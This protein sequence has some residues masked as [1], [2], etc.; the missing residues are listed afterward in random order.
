ML[1]RCGRPGSAYRPAVRLVSALCAV[2]IMFLY[3]LYKMR[4]PDSGLLTPQQD[5]PELEVEGVNELFLH[6][7]GLPPRL[8]EASRYDPKLLGRHL[9]SSN[10]PY[11]D[12]EAFGDD[13][14]NGSNGTACF[15]PRDKHPGYNTSCLY[16]LDQCGGKAQLFDYLRLVTC[17]FSHVQVRSR[18]KQ[19]PHVSHVQVGYGWE[20][21]Q[22]GYG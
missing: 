17:D 13:D 10:D 6:Q 16:V 11:K 22:V 19:L 18:G 7:E 12:L 1:A 8:S 9:L 21:V 4:R 2:G 20:H 15:S 5:P 3:G 14:D